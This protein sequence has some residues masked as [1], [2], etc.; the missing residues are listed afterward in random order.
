MKKI[1]AV[2]A[3][4]FASFGIASAAFVSPSS[5]DPETLVLESDSFVTVTFDTS[6]AAFTH[7]LYLV[8]PDGEDIFIFNNKTADANQT[9]NLGEFNAGTELIF[10]LYVQDTDNNYFTGPANRNPD[11]IVHA[12]LFL[13]LMT[14]AAIVGFEDQYLGGDMDFND[15]IFRVAAT[16]DQSAVPLPAAGLVFLTGLGL[17]RARSRKA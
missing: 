2:A 5:G 4:A 3:A 15:L 8:G 16:A 1:L 6:N 10:R 9:I 14:G 7:D 13:D 11:A 17:L 12:G